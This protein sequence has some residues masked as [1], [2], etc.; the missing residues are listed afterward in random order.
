MP[1]NRATCDSNTGHDGE[2]RM[3]IG[4]ALPAQ[5][6]G[7]TRKDVLGY[8][9]RAERLG[10]DS[11]WVL[12][13]LIYPSLA[14]L[15]L[16]MATAAVTERVKLG[17]SILLATLWNPVLLAKEAG[18]VQRMSDGRL[19]LGMA[20]GAREPDFQA[21]GV[22][23]KSRRR[24]FE[25]TVA[26]LRQATAGEP[27][28]HQGSVFQMKV[29]PV[30][31]PGPPPA[32][33][34]GGF[35]DD[36]V[37]RAVR[38]G[39]GF[40][41]GGRGPAF[42]RDAVPAVRKAAAEAGKDVKAFPIAALMYACFDRS[43]ERAV[44]TMT[45]YISGYYGRLIFEPAT[46]SICGGPSEGAARLREYA[47]LDVDTAIVVPVTRDPEQVDRLADAVAAFRQAA[48]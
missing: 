42:A 12:D 44:Q 41:V 43:A 35:V 30:T 18:T 5:V 29:G 7:V 32:I 3:K 34:L 33:W 1:G 22:S 23:M 38:L 9:E 16:L 21:A 48:K 8:A 25:E 47:A 27:I 46:Q 28:D 36:A 20:L 19:I 26:M 13:R 17:T 2:G 39:D 10:L 31:P 24:R 4:V 37:R 14:P 15:P 6:A 40:I 11:V 45:E